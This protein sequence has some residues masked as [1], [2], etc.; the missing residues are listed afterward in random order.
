EY[1]AQSENAKCA[2]MEFQHSA[3]T[4]GQNCL[5]DWLC[6]KSQHPPITVARHQST[7]PRRW[8]RTGLQFLTWLCRSG[9]GAGGAA[10]QLEVS[11]AC[12]DKHHLI[13]GIRYLPL[14]PNFV[15]DE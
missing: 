11:H 9:V 5:S 7:A 1:S 8:L 15:E 3:G 13:A 10:L 4:H 6:R 2:G 12:A 14:A